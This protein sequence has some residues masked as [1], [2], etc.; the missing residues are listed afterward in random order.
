[1]L[2]PF[3]QLNF[4][5]S[6]CSKHSVASWCLRRD[7]LVDLKVGPPK[8]IKMVKFFNLAFLWHSAFHMWY[9]RVIQWKNALHV[10]MKIRMT[11]ISGENSFCRGW[12]FVFTEFF[13]PS[14]F[15]SIQAGPGSTDT[16]FV[17]ESWVHRYT[18]SVKYWVLYFDRAWH[19]GN[20]NTAFRVFCSEN[21]SVS[22][23]DGEGSNAA[24]TNQSLQN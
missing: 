5:Q 15:I 6:H 1:M 8:T 18:F 10:V 9:Y 14:Q 7:Q 12:T 11:I 20:K 17:W 24:R 23:R 2:R 16:R 22:N 19:T 3:F 13:F 4:N 21:Y